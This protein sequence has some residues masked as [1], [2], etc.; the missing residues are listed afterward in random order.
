M[1]TPYVA[2]VAALMKANATDPNQI[3][4]E[5]VRN[6]LQKGAVDF[7]SAK[8]KSETVRLDL[9]GTA[10]SF[11]EDYLKSVPA[12]LSKPVAQPKPVE[13]GLP[14]EKDGGTGGGVVGTL[15]DALCSL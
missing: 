4:Q 13:S 9:Y 2:G 3:N 6:Q 15:W 5:F 14:K 7:P 8:Q 12:S 11:A 1:A 10:Y